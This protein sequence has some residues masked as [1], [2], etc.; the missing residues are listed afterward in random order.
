MPLNSS[1]LR[2]GRSRRLSRRRRRHINLDDL[3]SAEC[4]R[5]IAP[6]ARLSSVQ[7]ITDVVYLRIRERERRFCYYYYCVTSHMYVW[8]SWQALFDIKNNTLHSS[9]Y[10]FLN[11]VFFIP[12]GIRIKAIG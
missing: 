12:I 5:I 10:I 8:R 7:A 3:R 9:E 4:M 2:Q 1:A 11:V 6:S